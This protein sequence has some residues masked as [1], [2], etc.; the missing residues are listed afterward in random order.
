MEEKENERKSNIKFWN[1]ILIFAILV[2]LSIM[3]QILED[4]QYIFASNNIKYIVATICIWICQFLILKGIT[5]KTKISLGIVI[6]F[7]AFFDVINY[8]VKA[9]RGSTI[10]ISDIYAIKT[11]I[12]VSNSITIELDK[13]FWVGII[14]LIFIIAVFVTFRNYFTEERHE[15]KIR[16][17]EIF[18]GVLF[19]VTL[20]KTNLYREWPL[21]D[22]NDT[23][24]N[25]G[26]PITILRMTQ[27]LKVKPPIGYNKLEAGKILKHYEKKENSG[28]NSNIDE[29]PNIIV[30]VNESFCDYYNSYKDGY[31]NPIE[32]F[33]ELSKGENAVSGI[34]FSS[35]FGG[36]TS[37]VEY[38]FLT[39]NTTRVLP[40]GSYVFQQ[41]ISRSVK[42]SLVE[43]LES[44]GY[45]TSAIH[46]WE[47]F[48]YSRNKVYPL[49][50]F[51]NIKFKDDIE[52]LEKNFNNDFFS[53]RS[54]YRE[55]LRQINDKKKNEK[56]FE[57]VLTVQ[58]HIGYL[59]TDPKQID[60]SDDL[61]TNVYM[62]LLHESSEA[63]NE[64]IDE[65]K[66]K[67]EKYILLF[68][69]DH[70]P[71]LDDSDSGI[72][73]EIVQY[74]IPFL[75]WANYDIEEQYNI[76][77]ST[78]YLQ[79]LLLKSAGVEF[80]TMNNYMEELY[81]TYPIITK[82]FY[83][84]KEGIIYREDNDRTRNYGK[85]EEYDKVSYYRIFEKK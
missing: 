50:G 21:W 17:L 68:F 12:S 80:S 45:K 31:S 72:E 65:L 20:S 40:R 24:R 36:K 9:A 81:N 16:I 19:I 67:D 78:V 6:G 59:N 32:N 37:N 48:A 52:G 38:E 41:Y 15:I 39:Q 3:M 58:N 82:R 66:N 60:Y 27:D 46:P 26:S 18:I 5:N 84:D 14:S 70:Q 79:N 29:Y 54:T 71:N 62:Q 74:E 7:E 64:L 55:L 30:I 34:M 83:G 11:A 56:L 13:R 22:L 28:R 42:S 47:N 63:L 25:I 61:H 33:T 73:R 8:L 23:Y 53:D 35:E 4:F 51:D 76:T 69:G 77:T 85:I 10:A 44:L 57:Y 1:A 75:I 2:L 49:F 43:H